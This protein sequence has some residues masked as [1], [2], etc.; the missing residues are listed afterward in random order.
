[1]LTIRYSAASIHVDAFD[2]LQTVLHVLTIG[3]H[4]FKWI[5]L[6]LMR[7]CDPC[8]Q[9]I[10]GYTAAHY[11]VERDDLGTLQ[12]LTMRFSS[13]LKP[14]PGH[15]MLAIHERSLL[16]LTLTNQQGLTVF[17]LACHRE[18]LKCFRYLLELN[19]RDVDR[20]VGAL[21]IVNDPTPWCSLF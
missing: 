20:Q 18:S 2:S 12:A 11:A 13:T 21:V 1:M 14:F 5:R 15:Q 9:D 4:S 10:D 19:I 6:L 7:C 16:A 17:M 8:S 3:G